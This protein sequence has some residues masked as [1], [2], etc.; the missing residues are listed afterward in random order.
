MFIEE[1]DA[2]QI[3]AAGG[4][5]VPVSAVAATPE[6]AAD[7][8]TTCGGPVMVKAQV[9]AGKR[10]KGGGIVRADTPAEAGEAASR[11]LGMELGEHLVERVLVEQ[12]IDIAQELYVAFMVDAATAGPLLMIS[13]EGGMDIEEV[14]ATNP[15]AVH[16]ASIDIR[17]GVGAADALDAAGRITD[18]DVVR[19]DLA[20]VLITLYNL[21]RQHDAQLVEINPMA[22][23][24][25]GAVIALDCKLV[26]DDNA[27]YRQ[28]ELPTPR[29]TGTELELRAAEH[30]FLLVELDGD[31]GVLANGAGLT[32]STM[33]A[34]TALGGS[35]ANFLEV[36]GM[37]YKR[38]TP[39]L[40]LVLSN[41][42][43]KSLL[44]NLCG[45]YARTDVIAEGL[46]TGWKTLAPDIPVS[47]C[48]H[49]TGEE[50][51]QQLVRDELGLE[52][53]DLMDDAI[54]EAIANA[55]AAEGPASGD[56]A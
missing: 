27:V 32:M 34:V 53:H 51:A 31:V 54:R 18:D 36:G 40:E 20:G 25:E 37:A 44:V 1:A 4:V 23:T 52:C 29:P 47:F 45:A 38:A 17:H 14:H 28:G 43:V 13:A 33:D 2:K 12:R 5:P 19:A 46:I 30:D 49:G 9:P 39:A 10:G 11:I 7:A 8:A 48:I 35:P 26:I 22:I 16:M 6:E 3:I 42:K 50:R 21:F 24:T 41:P 56:P 55:A 15:E